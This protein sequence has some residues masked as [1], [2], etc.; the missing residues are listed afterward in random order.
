MEEEKLSTERCLQICDQLSKHI[1]QIQP[2][3]ERQARVPGATDAHS[4]PDTVINE[5]LQ[6][7]RDNLV[8]TAG[9]LERHMKDIVDRMVAK[10]RSTTTSEDDA[11]NLTRLHEEWETTRQCIDIC[12]KANSHMKD[13][14]SVIENYATGDAVQFMVSTDGKTLH[15]TN[16]GYGWRTRQLGGHLKDETIVQVSRDMA[17][18]NIPITGNYG[19]DPRT[20]P[21][22][23]P[24]AQTES[25]PP[26]TT[27]ASRGPGNTLAR[28]TT[29]DDVASGSVLKGVKG[30]SKR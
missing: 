29:P 5:G 19:A 28:K 4:V 22:S 8:V 24:D 30:S 16:R 3:P 2:L 9:K 11:T 14:I 10:T 15:G 25:T 26:S 7:C 21:P 27:W 20:H 6:N 1:D 13:N 18:L 17:T 12:A 23:G